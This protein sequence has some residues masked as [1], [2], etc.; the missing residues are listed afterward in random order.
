MTTQ[1][2][3]D[4]LSDRDIRTHLL[5]HKEET[6]RKI[7]QIA[8]LVPTAAALAN[9]TAATVILALG[10]K[11]PVATGA[12]APFLAGC[13]FCAGVADVMAK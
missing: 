2:A 9:L 11:S 7:L 3:C 5:K 1:T 12:A 4:N 13:Y 8:S 6:M 10:G